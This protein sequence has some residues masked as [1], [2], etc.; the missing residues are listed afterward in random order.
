MI[1]GIIQARM[2]STRLPGKVLLDLAGKPVVQRVLE[3]AQ[4]IVGVDQWILATTVL[5]EDD[6]IYALGLSLGLGVYRGSSTDVLDRYYLAAAPYG[7]DAVVRITADC[8]LLDPEVGSRVVSLFKRNRYDYVSNVHPPTFPDGLD[9]EVV[10][11]D[12]LCR[13]WA[14]AKGP[15][16]EHVTPY[17][18]KRPHK[19][20]C[21][22]LV[23]AT[24]LKEHR[25]TLDTS[26][27]YTWISHVYNRYAPA[28]PPGMEEILRLIHPRT[29]HRE[30]HL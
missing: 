10:T 5:P 6:A 8:P 16:R 4:R 20:R 18:W 11:Y 1:G 19:F 23:H 2:G 22:N 14:H 7:F 13:A 26:E 27:D 29:L 17:I 28:D 9:V 15:E 25:W 3:R 30:I 12:A 24:D 21:G